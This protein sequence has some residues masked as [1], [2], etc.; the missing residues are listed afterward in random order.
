MDN[1]EALK[2][3]FSLLKGED[4]PGYF[5]FALRVHESVFSQIDIIAAAERAGLEPEEYCIRAIV[6]KL[7]RD[8]AERLVENEKTSP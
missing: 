1:N 6:E 3:Y 7:A 2:K 5:K 4:E 8:Y